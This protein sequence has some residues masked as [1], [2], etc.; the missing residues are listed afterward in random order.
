MPAPPDYVSVAD[1]I[2]EFR[3]KHPN[4]CLRPADP[5]KPYEVVT[6][7][8]TTWIVV[9]AA[10]YRTPDDPCPGVGMAWEQ[11]PGATNFTR[12]SELQNAETSAWGRAIIAVGASDA[13]RGIATREEV[14][15]RTA[16]PSQVGPPA[17]M[18]AVVRIN[19]LLDTLPLADAAQAKATLE[20]TAG[21]NWRDTMTAEQ[22]TKATAWLE[23]KHD[24]LR[25]VAP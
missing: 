14:E 10:A 2:V 15:H 11:F 23:K 12:T 21:K 7:G 13:K 19:D 17:S 3:K 25:Q 24:A 18:E 6:I 20:S 5:A 1:R 9:V 4:G 16:V 22:A 8:E